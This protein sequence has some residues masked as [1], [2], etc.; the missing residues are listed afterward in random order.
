MN[1][2][3]IILVGS[4]PPLGG[5]LGRGLISFATYRGDTESLVRRRELHPLAAHSGYEQ[6]VFNPSP[7]HT[8]SGIRLP[9]MQCI[10]VVLALGTF[11]Q[12]LNVV[13]VYIPVDVVK[14]HRRPTAVTHSPDSMMNRDR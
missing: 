2:P 3:L 5:G 1:Y 12:V 9:W 4:L 8:R 10:E 11:P 14:R 13:V 7:R 6:S